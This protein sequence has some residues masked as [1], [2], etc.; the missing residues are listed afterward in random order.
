MNNKVNN[1]ESVESLML[2]RNLID[3]KIRKLTLNEM[4]K[5]YNHL[6]D[7]FGVDYLDY[8]TFVEKFN[9]HKLYNNINKEEVF[10]LKRNVNN[11]GNV[12][13]KMLVRGNKYI[14][15]IGSLCGPDDKKYSHIIRQRKK[16]TIKDNVLQNDVIFDNPSSAASFI[17]GKPV[18]GWSDWKNYQNKTLDEV[19]REIQGGII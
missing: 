17:V 2:E 19:R 5:I 6:L 15:L 18:N 7:E 3:K 14:V 16:E 11:F 1:K 9:S 12:K 13:G 10:F 8:E 4:E